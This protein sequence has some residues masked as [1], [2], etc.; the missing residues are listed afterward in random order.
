LKTKDEV[1]SRFQEF[2]A[3]AKN[4]TGK[5]IKLLHTNNGEEYTDSDFTN[6]C[7]KESIR[8]EW[9]SPYSPQHNGV[10]E[11]KKHKKCWGGKGYTI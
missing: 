7:G 3:L 6:F 11:R 5:K 9:T 1:F 10:A 2:K 8:R 4:L